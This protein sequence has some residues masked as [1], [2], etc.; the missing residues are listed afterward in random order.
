MYPPFLVSDF[1]ENTTLSLLTF[2]AV[3]IFDICDTDRVINR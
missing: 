3:S 2:V 1:T